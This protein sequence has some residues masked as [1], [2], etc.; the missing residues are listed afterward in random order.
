MRVR[1]EG[2]KAL[3]KALGELPRAVARRELRVIGN[4][5]LEP[6]AAM[7]RAKAPRDQGDLK[8]SIA[9]SEK[10]TRSARSRFNKDTGVQM[11]MGP[12]G[13]KGVLNYA[14]FQEFGTVGM[15]AN[16]Y[17]RP[18]WDAL[19]PTALTN[20]KDIMWARISKATARNVKRMA[21]KAST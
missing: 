5:V 19:A 1:V 12:S 18:T 7:A 14:S 16:P 6:M 11:A 8:V 21:K 9:I 20:I 17:M 15:P 2:L 13:G 4:T 10:R 3:D